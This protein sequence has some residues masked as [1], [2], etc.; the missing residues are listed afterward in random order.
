[1]PETVDL[2]SY[3]LGE[4]SE[5]RPLIEAIAEAGDD[6]E[7]ERAAVEYLLVLAAA[8]QAARG[9][10]AEEKAMAQVRSRYYRVFG[11]DD[12]PHA[13]LL[14]ELHESLSSGS[15][16]ALGTALKLLGLHHRK[17][18]AF[19][20]ARAAFALS[21]EITAHLPDVVEQLNALFWLGV[22]ERYL[23]D[24]DSAERVHQEQLEKA[25][26]SGSRSQAI[27]ALENL[28]LVSLRR[29]HV[30]EARSQITKALTE[31]QDVA[32][33][34]LEGYC[35]H[36][37]M[38]VEDSAGRP[39]EA[40]SCGWEAYRRYESKEQRLRALQDC[41]VTLYRW[42]QYDA[43][44]AAFD[45]VLEQS[46]DS[47]SRVRALTG[48]A[49]VAV[50]LDDRE[51]FDALRHDM[52]SDKSLN[53][54]PFEQASAYR[55]IGLGCSA[56]GDQARARE[57]LHQS[58]QIAEQKGFEAEAA[59]IRSRLADLPASIEAYQPLAASGEE[60]ERLEDVGQSII[61]ERARICA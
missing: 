18:G 20:L 6:R 47:A 24:L 37:L 60:S 13:R 32:D 52:L 45:I 3:L 44:S 56:F 36:A 30:T 26:I 19:R 1:M 59:E 57:F 17:L 58:L 8:R 38:V 34:E 11:R 40:A 46:D 29:G 54:M 5:L 43:A 14:R 12:T 28:G 15:A 42:G 31:A 7:R 23:G 10:P 27:L 21:V 39:G 50:A 22:T 4:R 35:Y 2:T 55:T 33:R 61:A 49:D 25:R 9:E 41:G 53:V 48:L 16:A 51:R